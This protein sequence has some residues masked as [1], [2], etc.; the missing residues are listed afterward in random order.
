MADIDAS[1]RV[2]PQRFGAALCAAG[3]TL[4]FLEYWLLNYCAFPLFDTVF[5]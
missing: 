1:G 2:R 5:I 4:S 3:L